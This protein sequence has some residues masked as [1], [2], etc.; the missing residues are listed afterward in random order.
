MYAIRSYYEYSSNGIDWSPSI[1]VPNDY[2]SLSIQIN[3]QVTVSSDIT[4]DQAIIEMEAELIIAGG[5]TLTIND[6]EGVDLTV[7]GIITNNGMAVS[8]S[9][10]SAIYSYN[11][12]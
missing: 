8:P 6:G 10:I 1:W 12:V 5:I 7:T 11:F 9:A 2:N 3:N 4:I